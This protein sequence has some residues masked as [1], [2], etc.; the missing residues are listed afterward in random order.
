MNTFQLKMLAVILMVVDH[1]GFFLFPDQIILRIIGR[2]S[3]PIFAYLITVGFHYTRNKNNY[4]LR[5]FIFA[6]IIQTPSL[7]MDIPVNIFFT[8]SLGLLLLI[9]YESQQNIINKLILMAI[10]LLFTDVLSPDYSIYGVILIFVLYF[11]KN[12]WQQAICMLVLSLSL[13]GYTDIQNFAVFA[14]IPI[15][16]YN[17][18]EGPK[19]KLFFYSF[20]PVHIVL[21][22]WISLRI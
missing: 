22:E 7:F 2:L 3:F 1:I 18:K 8:L 5:L 15:S 4:F 17:K 21:L 9:I 12:I 10:V 11:C 13:Y 19:W 14:L 6:A 16:F 20:Y